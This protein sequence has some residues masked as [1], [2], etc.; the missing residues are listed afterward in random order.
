MKFSPCF[1]V[2]LASATEKKVPPRTP[3]QRLNK[4]QQFTDE[5]LDKWFGFLP[6]KDAWKAKFRNNASRML[7]AY[8]RIDNGDNK[9]CG[10]YDPTQLPHGG[11]EEEGEKGWDGGPSFRKR[12]SGEDEFDVERYDKFVKG[13][14]FN[15]NYQFLSLKQIIISDAFRLLNFFNEK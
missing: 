8:E 7:K 10:F 15:C 2:A 5:I 9:K 4:M 11:P 3:E 12:R 13:K 14:Q 6:S 1:L